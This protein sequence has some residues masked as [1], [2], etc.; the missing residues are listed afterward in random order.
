MDNSKNVL[1]GIGFVVVVIGALFIWGKQSSPG[2]APIV[3]GT[4]ALSAVETSFDFGSISMAAGKVKHVFS[5]RNGSSTP[6][7][8]TKLYTSCMCT[9][10]QLMTLAKKVGPY[11]MPGHGFIPGIDI[12]LA[13]QEEAVVEAVF[14]PAA[15]GPAGVGK[16][17]RAVFVE[18]ETGLPFELRFTAQ[19]TP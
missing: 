17:E 19:V 5:I 6:V 15:H 3:S 9:T 14:D 13:P 7:R 10:A 8:L 18:T 16:I 12:T 1:I 11:G 2:V 4:S